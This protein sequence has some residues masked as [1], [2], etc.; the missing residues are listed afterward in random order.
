MTALKK[1]LTPQELDLKIYSGDG[2]KFRLFIKDGEGDPVPLTGEFIVQIRKT[3]GTD[4]DPDA[5][6]D[7]DESLFSE[8]KVGLSLTGAACQALAESA[9][10]KGFWDVQWTPDGAQP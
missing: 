8:G 4:T 3:R 1:D 9:K 6:F 5:E 10:F 7:I 2:Y